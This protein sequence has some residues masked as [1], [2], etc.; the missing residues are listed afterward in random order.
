[1]LM[2][3]SIAGDAP[4][5]GCL[6]ALALLA[7]GPANAQQGA[8]AEPAA[9]VF[10]SAF[11]TGYNP[12]TA[13]DMV[14]RV[15]GFEIIDGDDRRGF[16]ATAGNV[17]INGERPSSKASISDQLKRVPAGSVLRLE[18]ISGSSGSADAR[19]QSRIVNVILRPSE[20]G[21][22][23][24][25]WVLGVR[26]LE[27]SNRLGY[28]AQLSRSLR[29]AEGLDLSLDLQLPNIRGR[30]QGEEVVRGPTGAITEYRQQFNQPNFIGM[31]LAGSLK[32]RAGENDRV[33]VN[34]FLNTSDNSTGIGSVVFLPDG[35]VKSQT[36]GRA[37]YPT[38]ARGEIGADWER[39]LSDRLTAKLLVLATFNETEQLQ[40]LRTFAPASLFNTQVLSTAASGGERVARAVGTFRMNE[41]HTLEFG[42]EGAF[43]F[44]ETRLSL[45]NQKPGQSVVPVAFSVADT[46][47][48]ELRAEAFLTDVWTI[49]DALS[50]EAG[51]TFEAS[52]ITQSGDAAKE[53]EFTYPKPQFAATY[54]PGPGSEVRASLRRDVAQLDFSEFAS[55]FNAIDVTTIVGNPNLE[56]EKAWKAK[57]E[58]DQR[59]GQLGAF[60]VGL[61][62]DAVEDVRDLVVIGANDAYGNLGDG[63]RTGVE[64]RGQM[65]LDRF[66]LPRAEIRFNGAFQTTRVRDPLTG[67][68]RSFSSGDNVSSGTRS[69]GAAGGP[70]P[71]NIGNRDW[72]YVASFR[73]EYPEL[74]SAFSMSIARNARREE[75][76]RVET[77]TQDR[78]IERIDLNWDTTAIPGLTLRF[79]LGNILSPPEERVRTFYTG[80]RR[81]DVIA[82][83]ETR[84][85]RGGPDG[86]MTYSIQASGK[87]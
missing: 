87:F 1:M 73:Q 2:R 50:L 86:T 27:Y 20:A 53:R 65:P 38:F 59:S 43:N 19:G 18:L 48:E 84:P 49:S 13:G 24:T 9:Q 14:A 33:N 60:T 41:A 57:V 44:R 3:L 76:R 17:L 26:H 25:T 67:E 4:G 29:L 80:D 34:A 36:F 10:E 58:W 78:A 7:S 6:F 5:P 63:T 70:P 55:S 72:G 54:R 69:G 15:P 74:K 21:G 28:T 83:T 82:R 85:Y 11:F 35:A 37:E 42:G 8:P 61:F 66:G 40:T 39:V 32:W 23:P 77:I 30:T 47:I 68:M 79:G 56:P 45:T 31:Q 22:S 51:F 62:H 12:V 64:F 71:L 46:R 52:R 75:S 16:G 81:S